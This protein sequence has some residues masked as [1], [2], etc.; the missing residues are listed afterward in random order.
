MLLNGGLLS[1]LPLLVS[2]HYLGSM[3]PRNLV[4][5]V[6]LYTENKFYWLLRRRGSRHI[7]MPNFVSKSV[8]R[9]QRRFFSIFQDGGRR[10]LRLSNSQNFID[11]QCLDGPEA[12]PYQILSKTAVPLRRYCNFLNFQDGRRR[13]LGFL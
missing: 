12:S 7:S 8:N 6:M 13:Y 4:S 3:N 10:H 11:C 1:H 9:L 5:S 2:L